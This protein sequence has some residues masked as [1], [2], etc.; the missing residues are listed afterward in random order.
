MLRRHT[1]DLYSNSSLVCM[2]HCET[3]SGVINEVEDIS[4]W[5]KTSFCPSASFFVD[6]MS[7]FGAVPLELENV[8]FMVSS[9]NKCLQGVPGFSYAICRKERL[10]RCKGNSRSLRYT[11]YGHICG[12]E[13]VREVYILLHSSLDLFDQNEGLSKNGQFRFTPPTHTIM[14][15]RQAL[16]EFRA[17]GGLEGRGKR[18]REN[19]AILRQAM[20]EMGFKELVPFEKSGYIITSYFYPK[21]TNF[22]C[23]V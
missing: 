23:R 8:D 2:V 11:E 3:S 21:A 12:R 4:R 20:E 7:S 22:S 17:E 9:A 6:A 14:A 5:C 19:R 10:E 15:F 18:Y 1:E 13:K 16:A